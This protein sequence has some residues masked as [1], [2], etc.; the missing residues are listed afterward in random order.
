MDE[1]N[2]IDTF[3]HFHPNVKRYSW[4]KQNPVKQTRLD[5]FLTSNTM[6]NMVWKLN[7][8]L[9]KN[10]DYVNLVNR[11][12]ED[13][14]LKYVLAVYNIEYIRNMDKK[15]N[16]NIDPDEFLEMIYLTVTGE[17][18]KF[19]SH[20]KNVNTKIEKKLISEIENMESQEN[21]NLNSEI[22]NCRKQQLE[23]IREENIQ[24]QIVRS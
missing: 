11:I 22:L 19:A 17:T 3:R 14:K 21:T 13:E 6:S 1:L 16:F 8:G 5:F 15:L 9:L 12:I 7:V 20:L 18:I 10:P 24:G 2:L 4:R 23:K